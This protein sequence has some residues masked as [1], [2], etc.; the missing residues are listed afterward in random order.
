MIPTEVKIGE[1]KLAKHNKIVNNSKFVMNS[2]GKYVN[3]SIR[4]P[5]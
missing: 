1:Q 4:I 3:Q 2:L 5:Q